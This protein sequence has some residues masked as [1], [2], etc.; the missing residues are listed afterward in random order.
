M[1]I[2][3][4]IKYIIKARLKDVELFVNYHMPRCLQKLYL[5]P[6]YYSVHIDQEK[7]EELKYVKTS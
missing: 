3:L 4:L 7:I 5:I 6:L 1:F 2:F